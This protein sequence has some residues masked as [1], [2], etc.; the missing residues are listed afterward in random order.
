MSY[1]NFFPTYWET[2]LLH[3]LEKSL[4][5]GNP[6]I[7]NRD[8]EGTIQNSGDTVRVMSLGDPTIK[9]Y[10]RT[11]PLD[12]P[13]VLTGDHMDLVIDQ[14]HYFNFMVHDV[15]QVQSA[16]DLFEKRLARAAYQLRD[17]TDR[18]LANELA[19]EAEHEL[20]TLAAPRTIKRIGGK[21]QYEEAYEYLVD[22]STVLNEANVPMEGRWVVIPPFY[23]AHL[24]KDS[25]FLRPDPTNTGVVQSLGYG[26]VGRAVDFNVYLS[27]NVVA[28]TGGDAG[29]YTITAGGTNWATSL[30]VQIMNIE[31]YRPESHFSDAIKGLYVYG[32]KVFRPEML[33]NLYVERDVEVVP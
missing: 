1:A 15:D 14:E 19:T 26:Y 18:H 25:R 24:L 21:V 22:L 33:A 31:A 11:Q 8:Y 5:F 9:P 10:D 4:V 20:G 12:A 7:A 30:A 27:N 3:A 16:P 23:H 29:K 32:L 17:I 6:N 28:G 2:G 13:E